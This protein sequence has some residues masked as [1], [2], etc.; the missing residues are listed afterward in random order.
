MEPHHDFEP[1]VET[2]DPETVLVLYTDG[3]VEPREGLQ[4]GMDMLRLN[5]AGETKDP[6]TMCDHI[7]GRM[8]DG[9]AE[10]DVA[11]LVLR[12]ESGEGSAGLP[13]RA[14]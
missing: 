10:D 11:L 9:E 12:L 13:T 8:L 6:E 7:L 4:Y 14:Q 2:L 3:L 5:V 1:A